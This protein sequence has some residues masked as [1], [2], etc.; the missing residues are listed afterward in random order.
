V[1]T[2][3]VYF[4]S[5]DYIVFRNAENVSTDERTACGYKL[6]FKIGEAHYLFTMLSCAGWAIS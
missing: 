6:V 2:V 4:A 1:K 3:T 5:G